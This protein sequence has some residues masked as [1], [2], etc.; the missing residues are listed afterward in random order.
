MA[1]QQ[2]LS[3][4]QQPTERQRTDTRGQRHEQIM[5]GAKADMKR[6]VRDAIRSGTAEP[7]SLHD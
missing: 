7:V 2:L 5:K 4:H 6:L 3:V 1:A